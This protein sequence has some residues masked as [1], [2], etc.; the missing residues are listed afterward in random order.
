[1]F[2]L[3][4]TVRASGEFAGTLK[5]P[6]TWLFCALRSVIVSACPWLLNTNELSCPLCS[7]TSS[8]PESAHPEME[9]GKLAGP[10]SAVHAQ[11]ASFC[12][13]QL[14]GQHE[15]LPTHCTMALPPL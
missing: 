7:A 3:T 10:P 15:S 11:S 2:Q 14:A 4:F 6:T 5:V 13:V 1:M 12:G 8:S 9:F